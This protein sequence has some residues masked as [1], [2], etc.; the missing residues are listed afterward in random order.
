MMSSPPISPTYHGGRVDASLQKKVEFA[1]LLERQQVRLYGYM[2]S[3]VHNLHD[4]EDLF[5]QVSLILWRKFDEFDRRRDFLVWACGIA[6]LEAANF[7]RSRNRRQLYFSDEVSL[8]LIEAQASLSDEELEDRRECLA[9]CI[10]K[11]RQRDRDLVL[12][13]Y[14]EDNGVQ[15]AA[16]AQ[17]RS[18]QSIYN[19][20]RRIRLA[21]YQCIQSAMV[22]A[23]GPRGMPC[24]SGI[25][26]PKS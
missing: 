23:A 26:L 17:G 25:P 11:L 20:L 3:L 16:E 1:Y 5:Q 2:H 9:S 4:A 10:D 7:L 13:C 19:S 21:L 18:P 14:G 12:N 22:R 8:L 6:R 15:A 24:T